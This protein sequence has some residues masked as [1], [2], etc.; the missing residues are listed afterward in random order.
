MTDPF[1]C[2]GCHSGDFADFDHYFDVQGWEDG[3]EPEAFGHWLAGR[4][5]I[6]VTAEE[7]TADD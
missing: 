2:H 3:Q 1:T 7:V 6:D 4:F 5:K